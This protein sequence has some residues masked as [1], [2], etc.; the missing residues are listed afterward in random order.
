MA[1]KD[2]IEA[3]NDML[4]DIT[5]VDQ[6]FDGK[7]VVLGGDFRQALL[8]IPKGTHEDCINA[9][10]VRSATWPK[11]KKFK[12]KENMTPRTDP[13]FSKYLLCVGDGVEPMDHLEQIHIPPNMI[14][15]PVIDTQPIDQLIDFVFPDLN[16]YSRNAITM[17]N[18]AILTPKNNCVDEI[19]DTLMSKF[20]EDEEIY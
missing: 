3:L 4:R 11:L 18:S 9:S 2:N 1:K 6:L 10:L 16:E 8:V 17:T 19:N 12:L 15:D 13:S 7:V 20:P 14:L 5:D